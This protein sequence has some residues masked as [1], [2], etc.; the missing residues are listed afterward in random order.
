[1]RRVI[2]AMGLGLGAYLVAHALER[3]SRNLGVSREEA[4]ESLPGDDLVPEPAHS[5]THGIWIPAPPRD[6]WPWLVQMGCGR[7]GWYAI[8]H[9]DN[10]GR[11]SSGEIH[12]D[13]QAL[14]VGDV[15]DAV[16]GGG[17]GFPVRLIAERRALVFGGPIRA[18]SGET[19][20]APGSRGA[21]SWAFA[22]RE[23]EGGRTRLLVRARRS[24]GGVWYEAPARLVWTLG[25]APMQLIQ[26]RRIRARAVS[27][28]ARSPR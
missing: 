19:V 9:I 16:P 26:L 21:F 6:V 15:L 18:E 2:A 11:P 14:G 23:A 8:D 7:A 4:R 10:G 24:A 22:L 13:W 20:T 27:T 28:G 12:P 3:A 25:H 17:I 5:S 1:M